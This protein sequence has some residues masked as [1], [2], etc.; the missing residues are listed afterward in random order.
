[1]KENYYIYGRRYG[2]LFTAEKFR[3]NHPFIA[4]FTT[5]DG[6]GILYKFFHW[7]PYSKLG[8]FINK[9]DQKIFKFRYDDFDS[10]L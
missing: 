7:Y 8:N 4:R 10:Y 6:N 2:A 1:M 9:I 5:L 3:D